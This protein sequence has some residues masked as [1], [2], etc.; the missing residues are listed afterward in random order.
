MILS[1]NA[2]V[3]LF[4]KVLEQT[5]GDIGPFCRGKRPRRL[6]TVLS[7]EEVRRMLGEL[8]G[9]AWMIAALLYG[10]G[11]RLVEC[12]QPH[13]SDVESGRRLCVVRCSGP[14]PFGPHGF[15][16]LHVPFS[17]LILKSRLA[18]FVTHFLFQVRFSVLI[19]RGLV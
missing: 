7:R 5:L 12:P 10:S 9:V 19:A 16:V 13:V 2:L 18:D 14:T 17:C 15:P 4:S 3:F 11:V 8:G 1:Q 6:P